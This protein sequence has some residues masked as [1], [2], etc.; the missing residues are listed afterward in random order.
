M[1]VVTLLARQSRAQAMQSCR[2]GR[3]RI[4]ESPCKSYRLFCLTSSSLILSPTFPIEAA[5]TDLRYSRIR[6]AEAKM[7]LCSQI[8][9]FCNQHQVKQSPTARLFWARK[10]AQ[11]CSKGRKKSLVGGRAPCRF[12]VAAEAADESEAL[13]RPCTCQEQAPSSR[14][15]LYQSSITKLIYLLSTQ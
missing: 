4:A 9:Q 10:H 11:V 8:G 14:R 12:R 2:S 6:F 13:V 5:S 1:D 3:S 15:R 7:G